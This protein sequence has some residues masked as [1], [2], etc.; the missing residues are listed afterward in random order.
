MV[1]FLLHY[2]DLTEIFIIG[3]LTFV[4]R[5]QLELI[6][7]FGPIEALLRYILTYHSQSEAY[8]K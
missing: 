5:S 3:K 7:L 2:C 8:I 4:H 1:V 6:C